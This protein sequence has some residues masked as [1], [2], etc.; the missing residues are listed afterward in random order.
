MNTSDLIFFWTTTL[1]LA[2]TFFL[3]LFS[4]VFGRQRLFALARLTILLA[5]L[6]LTAFGIM[7]WARTGHP[8]FVTLF[9]S[10]ITAVWFVL[11]ITNGIVSRLRPAAIVILP[12]SGITFLLM[13]WASDL[14]PDLSPLSAALTNVWLFIHASFA[15]SGAAAFLIAASFSITY[16]LGE[17]GLKRAQRVV[18]T[19]PRYDSLPRSVLNLILFGLIL[20]GVMIVSGSI[21]A[22]VAWGRYWAWDPIETW[23]L[24]SWLLYGLLLH[25]RLTFKFPPRLFCWLTIIAAG[26]VAFS[27]WGIHYIYDTIHTYG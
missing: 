26:T 1:L 4:L 20:W 16:L 2:L 13:G 7:R 14:P 21:W 25:A 9:E 3:V 8:P 17:K 11:L 22:H 10:M 24:I 18:A 5:L 6:G 12:V 15:T 27:L 19:I 23:S